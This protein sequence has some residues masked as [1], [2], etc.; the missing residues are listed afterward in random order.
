MKTPTSENTIIL[1]PAKIKETSFQNIQQ[2]TYQQ[3]FFSIQMGA[4]C[5]KTDTG[6]SL[7]EL[8]E[9]KLKQ[10]STVYPNSTK[11]Q[12]LLN[13][14]GQ[15]VTSTT[16]AQHTAQEMGRN[17]ASM[18]RAAN[19]FARSFDS[20]QT[21]CSTLHVRGADNIFSLYTFD[22]NVLAFY[23]HIPSDELEAASTLDFVSRDKELQ[24]QI[25]DGDG[26]IRNLMKNLKS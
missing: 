14:D 23:S 15:L 8:I 7:L 3:H 2:K 22:K 4:C 1:T 13:K 9:A 12:I 20:K 19:Q 18:K 16:N 11:L 26:G 5:T 6:P 25:I 10:I 24:L 21:E 17:I